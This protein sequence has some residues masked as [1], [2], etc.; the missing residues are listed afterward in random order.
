MVVNDTWKPEAAVTVNVAYW[1]AVMAPASVVAVQFTP[2]Q[3]RF[4]AV[5][6]V[7]T[8]DPRVR[9]PTVTLASLAVG[10]NGD[11]P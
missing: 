8:P 2:P 10:A 11:G 5:P 3:A 9:P 6:L 1:F 4:A 7:P